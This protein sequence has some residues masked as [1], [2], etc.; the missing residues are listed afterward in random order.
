[1]SPS[2][3]ANP[4][5]TPLSWWKA[6]P[7]AL[8]A[9]VCYH[10]AYTPAQSGLLAFAIIGYVICLVQ[11]ARVRTTRQCFYAA[12]ATGFACFAP[13]LGFFWRIF[14]AA[15]DRMRQMSG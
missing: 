11:L 1:M 2:S 9:V 12:L 4:G 7:L 8:I 15:Y 3:E 13:Q 10:A 14:G 5:F 6:G